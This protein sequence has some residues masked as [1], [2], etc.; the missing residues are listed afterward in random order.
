MISDL[1]DVTNNLWQKQADQKYT[2]MSHVKF[3]L[4]FTILCFKE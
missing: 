2:G 3:C 4:K 1:Q